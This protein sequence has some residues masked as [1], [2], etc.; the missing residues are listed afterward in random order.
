MNTSNSKE[1]IFGDVFSYRLITNLYIII[2]SN[3]I[4]LL[5]HNKGRTEGGARA[6][7]RLLIHSLIELVFQV[8]RK[9]AMRPWM[10]KIIN[11]SVHV[12]R[13]LPIILVMCIN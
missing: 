11:T 4:M 7:E 13:Q 3:N 10:E 2:T 6:P 8:I 1:T 9:Y 5:T 12:C